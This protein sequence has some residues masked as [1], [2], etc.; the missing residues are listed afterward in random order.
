[1]AGLKCG[2]AGLRGDKSCTQLLDFFKPDADVAQNCR[3]ADHLSVSFGKGKNCEL[4]GYTKSVLSNRR[5]SEKVA[6][7]ITSNACSHCP[8]IAI[9]MAHTQ[10][11]RDNDIQ[12]VSKCIRLRKPEYPFGAA[13]P[14]TD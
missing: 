11:L 14:K 9:P 2:I 3:D 10:L 7:A 6:G 8:R 4:D 12:V 1:M 5:N 13:V